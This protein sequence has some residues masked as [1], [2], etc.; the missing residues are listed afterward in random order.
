MTKQILSIQPPIIPN[1][2]QPVS[3]SGL[4]DNQQIEAAT[5]RDVTLVDLEARGVLIEE[6]ALTDVEISTS[7]LKKAMLTDVFFK[8]C[9]LFGSNLDGSGLHRVSFEKG[10]HSGIVLSDAALEDVAFEDAKLNLANFRVAK[11]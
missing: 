3:L 10:M 7:K 4:Q 6:S 2:L 11:L 1:D 8:N 5:L 9:L